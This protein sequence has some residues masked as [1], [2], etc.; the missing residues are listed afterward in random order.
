[1]ERGYFRKRRMFIKKRIYYDNT[2]VVVIVAGVIF[3]K[4]N[5]APTGG[6][7]SIVTSVFTGTGV[8]LKATSI[9]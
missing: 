8:T 3:E 2:F 7:I 6:L 4:G 9:C 1:M 5:A